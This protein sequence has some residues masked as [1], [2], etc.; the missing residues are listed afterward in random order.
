M[1]LRLC[2]VCR[3]DKAN[4]EQQKSICWQALDQPPIQTYVVTNQ[5]ITGRKKPLIEVRF[6]V[7]I[8]LLIIF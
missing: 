5:T 6:A 8:I 2:S 7:N 4:T 3:N 1:F